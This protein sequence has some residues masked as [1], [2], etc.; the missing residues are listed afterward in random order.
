M[1][2]RGIPEKVAMRISDHKTRSVFDR[3]NIVSDSEV[4]EAA[5]KIATWPDVNEKRSATRTSTR[6]RA[7]ITGL[8]E[9]S[10]TYLL[11]SNFRTPPGWRNWQTH[12]T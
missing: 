7:P 4:E 10:I 1:I 8:L 12:G 3:Y 9:S 2:R 5:L 6:V 11:F